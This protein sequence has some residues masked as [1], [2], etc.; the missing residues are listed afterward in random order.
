MK[1]FTGIRNVNN[2]LLISCLNPTNERI[3]FSYHGFR[4]F[5]HGVVEPYLSAVEWRMP[6]L[7]EAQHKNYTYQS[8]DFRRQ[9]DVS[10]FIDK[11]KSTLNAFSLEKR[12]P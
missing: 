4:V 3:D 5:N 7:S 8:L 1:I 9:E 11:V 12:V 6:N 2:C 10:R